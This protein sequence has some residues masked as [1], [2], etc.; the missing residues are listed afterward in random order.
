MGA[1]PDQGVFQNQLQL[2]SNLNLA[3]GRHTLSF[4]ANWNYTQLNIINHANE[5]ATLN[6]DTFQ[7]FLQGQ[8]D[9]SRSFLLDGASNR[10][11]RAKQV[12]AYAQ[13]KFRATKN[14]VVTLGLRFDYD[15]PLSEKYGNLFQL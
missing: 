13:D 5:V 15:G 14:L 6:F 3:V 2:S 10:Y 8:L 9:T 4:G 1:S 7:T 12:G 11:Y